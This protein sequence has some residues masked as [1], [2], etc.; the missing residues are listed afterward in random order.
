[1]TSDQRKKLLTLQEIESRFPTYTDDLFALQE[2]NV[3]RRLY[4]IFAQDPLIS[5][6][7]FT[8]PIADGWSEFDYAIVS[9]STHYLG[10]AKERNLNSNDYTTSLVD[11]SK[12]S[13]LQQLGS[14]QDLPVLFT[15]LFDDQVALTWNINDYI[16]KSTT[17][18]AVKTLSD[19]GRTQKVMCH[20]NNSEASKLIEKWS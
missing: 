5:K 13:Q 7:L 16:S 3:R 14:E 6:I 10:E 19:K 20:Y 17:N 9:A 15:C 4:R 18:C 1:M 12:I 2:M 8:D 11:A